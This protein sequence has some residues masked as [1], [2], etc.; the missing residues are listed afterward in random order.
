MI[1]HSSNMI[2]PGTLYCN[3]FPT[4]HH[5]LVGEDFSLKVDYECYYRQTFSE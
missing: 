2:V 3:F 1:Y 5:V 4:K